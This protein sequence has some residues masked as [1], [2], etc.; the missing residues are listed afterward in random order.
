MEQDFDITI[1]EELTQFDSGSKLVI[2]NGGVLL[3]RTDK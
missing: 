1:L 2:S 3:E